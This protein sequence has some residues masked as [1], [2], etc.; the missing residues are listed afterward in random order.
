[1]NVVKNTFYDFYT[2]PYLLFYVIIIATKSYFML[3]ITCIFI[4]QTPIE[5]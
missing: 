2:D 5:V 3:F 4:F 1:M